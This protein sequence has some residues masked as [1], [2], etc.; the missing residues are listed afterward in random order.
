[1]YIILN[2]WSN[3]ILSCVHVFKMSDMSLS[4]DEELVSEEESLNQKSDHRALYYVLTLNNYTLDEY[5]RFMFARDEHP[6]ISYIIFA[7]EK[8]DK[9]TPHLQGYMEFQSRGRKLGRLG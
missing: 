8:G 4:V 7:K 3:F 1:M 2:K 6:E 9:G 5:D